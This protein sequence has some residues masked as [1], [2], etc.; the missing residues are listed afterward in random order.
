M[1]RAAQSI[2]SGWRLLA[3]ILLLLGSIQTNGFS[4]PEVAAAQARQIQSNTGRAEISRPVEPGVQERAF[5]P[6]T[7]NPE[8][9]CPTLALADL[10]LEVTTP[11]AVG[12]RCKG[13][14]NCSEDQFC[15]VGCL[16]GDPDC[17]CGA[18]GYCNLHE[19]C[20]D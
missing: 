16:A 18:D 14:R 4:P 12:V 15:D 1:K 6:P 2:R 5:A 10:S 9:I 11:G 17:G 20:E 13:P 8:G 19:N 7:L 3:T